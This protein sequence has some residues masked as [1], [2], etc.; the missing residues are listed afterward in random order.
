M[1]DKD[2]GE[3]WLKELLKK[4]DEISDPLTRAVSRELKN[5]NARVAQVEADEE[6]LRKIKAQLTAE[7][8]FD[9]KSSVFDSIFDPIRSGILL[10]LGR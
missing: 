9:E 5:E 7:G 4:E 6:T 3:Q 10:L 2:S 1:T 8:Y